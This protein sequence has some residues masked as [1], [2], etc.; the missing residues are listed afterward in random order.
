M[1]I[2]AGKFRGTKLL[3]LEGQATRPTSDNVKESI[4]NIIQEYFP[5]DKVLDLFA[6]S[7]ALGLEALSRGAEKVIFVDSNKPA[8]DIIR[9]NV[10]KL[11]T[12]NISILQRDYLQYI[13]S[14]TDK[15]DVIF[16]DPPYNKGY[17][18]SAVEAIEQN[19]LLSPDGIL[20][21]E[22]EVDGENVDFD[23]FEVVTVKKYGKTQITILK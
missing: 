13:K 15:F 22:S 8:L 21:I 2:I 20:V 6:G 4:F 5:C 12:P 19:E 1:R 11:Q 14:A 7:G 23:G 9:K 3:S 17:L 18:K 10:E 16:L